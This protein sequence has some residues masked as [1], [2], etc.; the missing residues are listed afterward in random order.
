MSRVATMVCGVILLAAVSVPV[1]SMYDDRYDDSMRE[2]AD[3]T[4]LMLDRFWTSESDVL[5]IRGWEILPSPDSSLEIDGNHLTVN[6]KDGSF[7]TLIEHR[8]DAFSIG[9]NDEVHIS[10]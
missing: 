4:S 8:M 5:T 6:N 3:R 2:T 1:I 9:Y 7:S 10:K